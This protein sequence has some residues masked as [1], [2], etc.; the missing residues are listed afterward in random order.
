MIDGTTKNMVDA[1]KVL[2]DF[3][4]TL[5]RDADSDARRR[6][7]GGPRTDAR[8]VKSDDVLAGEDIRLARAA[9]RIAPERLKTQTENAGVERLVERQVAHRNRDM[10]NGLDAVTN[11]RDHCVPPTEEQIVTAKYKIL[12]RH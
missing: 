1:A 4:K 3:G 12:C 2:F 7:R 10:I 8:Q 9:V 11:L 5:G 6:S